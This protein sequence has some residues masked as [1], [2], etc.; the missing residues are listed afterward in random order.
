MSRQQCLLLQALFLMSCSGS[1]SS[2]GPP[3]NFS[4]LFC[5]CHCSVSH[6]QSRTPL[7][8]P[9]GLHSLHCWSSALQVSASLGKGQGKGSLKLAKVLLVEM[10]WLLPRWLKPV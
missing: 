1:S 5:C 7:V 6:L 4:S 2:F 9:A 8:P 3:G 10:G